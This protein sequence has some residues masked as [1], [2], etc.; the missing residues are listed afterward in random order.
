MLE[1]SYHSPVCHVTNSDLGVGVREE[2]F[3]LLGRAIFR[4]NLLLDMV[5]MKLEE[6]ESNFRAVV[7]ALLT[8]LNLH[9]K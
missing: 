9:S 3:A 7:V 2:N 5:R 4:A 8:N 6:K 1:K